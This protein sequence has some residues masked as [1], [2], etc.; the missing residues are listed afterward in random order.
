MGVGAISESGRQEAEAEFE[1]VRVFNGL[2]GD[3]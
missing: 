1:D 3:T 2:T